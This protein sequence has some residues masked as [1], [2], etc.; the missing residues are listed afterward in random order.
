MRIIKQRNVFFQDV[1]TL[2]DED[3][4]QAEICQVWFEI[5][6]RN[7]CNS[8]PYIILSNINKELSKEEKLVNITGKIFVIFFFY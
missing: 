8:K 4:D 1:L 6:S 2:I 7:I 3:P 5:R